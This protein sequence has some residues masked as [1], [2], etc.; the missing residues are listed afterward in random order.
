MLVQAHLLSGD[1]R[2]VGIELTALDLERREE[3]VA[4]SKLEDAALR[5]FLDTNTDDGPPL[6]SDERTRLERRLQDLRDASAPPLVVRPYEF[7]LQRTPFL[8]ALVEREDPELSTWMQLL[9]LLACR[10]RLALSQR[11]Y[12][13]L[14]W[15]LVP[16]VRR[17]NS[18]FVT[19]PDWVKRDL[20]ISADERV[21]LLNASVGFRALAGV[22]RV[23]GLEP[24]PYGFIRHV[25]NVARA[26]ELSA[27]QEAF[28]AALPSD[29]AALI[30]EWRSTFPGAY[31]DIKMRFALSDEDDVGTRAYAD[32][33][34][35]EADWH[36]VHAMSE[37]HH[38]STK[39][40]SFRL[41]AARRGW[42]VMS[43][44]GLDA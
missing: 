23:A 33:L 22:G 2:D 24:S 8:R 11:V 32:T 4:A 19:F 5:R 3:L 38:A 14:L 12:E 40:R 36:F 29:L 7:E 26:E 31:H 39:I 43:T 18:S 25:P 21:A 13:S 16:Q 15:T 1:S 42:A 27:L 41:R 35:K 9:P 17:E 10:D 6:S 44:D 28:E 20:E 34:R 37:V 30:P